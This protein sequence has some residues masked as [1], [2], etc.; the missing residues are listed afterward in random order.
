MPVALIISLTVQLISKHIQD[1]DGGLLGCCSVQYFVCIPVFQRNIMPQSSRQMR[2]CQ[3]M[4]CL[5][6]ATK[7]F[8][9][10][11]LAY[12]ENNIWCENLE[13]HHTQSGCKAH[14]Q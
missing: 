7:R 8:K 1:L 5:C 11:V 2:G 4:D 10:G 3:Q 9:P 14:S 6:W 13:N 12:S